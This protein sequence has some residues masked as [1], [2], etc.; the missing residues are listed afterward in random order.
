MTAMALGKKLKNKYRAFEAIFVGLVERS[1]MMSV[2]DSKNGAQK[3]SAVQRP[4][5]SQREDGDIMALCG[6][7]WRPKPDEPAQDEVPVRVSAEPKATARLARCTFAEGS[8]GGRRA[9]IRK[10]KELVKYWVH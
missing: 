10:H 3:V 6:L 4:S 1:D 9:Y 8:R 2:I 5:E 7:P